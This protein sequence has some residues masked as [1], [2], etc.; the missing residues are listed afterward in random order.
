[1]HR[2]NAAPRWRILAAAVV[3][4]APACSKHDSHGQPS[5]QA[6]A[7]VS[8]ATPSALPPPDARPTEGPLDPHAYLH[9]RAIRLM[10]R[11]GRPRA[12][13]VADI[14]AKKIAIPSESGWLEVGPN[15]KPV[16]FSIDPAYAYEI[17]FEAHFEHGGTFS[18]ASETIESAPRAGSHGFHVSEDYKL[19]PFAHGM[20]GSEPEVILSF[21]I[22]SEP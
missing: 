1:M 19:Y 5:A 17:Y 9:I 16:T 11:E 13:I 7:A 2:S 15:M 14:G 18:G 20:K 22:S 6:S 12:R 3:A 21:E 8:S 10:H 4:C